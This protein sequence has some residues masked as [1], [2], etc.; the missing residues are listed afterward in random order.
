[1]KKKICSCFYDLSQI[2]R[3]LKSPGMI[4]RKCH[5]HGENDGFVLYD[6]L[7]KESSSFTN[8]Q[9]SALRKKFSK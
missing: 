7:I 3:Y 2:P 1:M 4:D 5:G 9:T 6:F 8:I